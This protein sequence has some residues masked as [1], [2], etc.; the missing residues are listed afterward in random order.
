MKTPTF[1]TVA[2]VTIFVLLS[3]SIGFIFAACI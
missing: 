2:E 3:L 1:E